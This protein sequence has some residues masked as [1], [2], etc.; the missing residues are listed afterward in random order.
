MLVP[1]PPPVPA[2]STARLPQPLSPTKRTSAPMCNPSLNQLIFMI[3]P[4]YRHNPKPLGRPRRP[5]SNHGIAIAADLGKGFTSNGRN[6][7]VTIFDLKTLKPN[8][9]GYITCAVKACKSSSASFPLHVR[10]AELVQEE[11]ELNRDFIVNILPR[12]EWPALVV[13]A[14]EVPLPSPP[15]PCHPPQQKN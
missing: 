5:S 6:N 9:L 7:T 3:S 8:P 11:L 14:R 10:D 15:L 1:P 12:I 4:M 2:P 13:T